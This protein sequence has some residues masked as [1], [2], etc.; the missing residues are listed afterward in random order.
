MGSY[1]FCFCVLIFIL[2]QYAHEAVGQVRGESPESMSLQMVERDAM[3]A[4]PEF[5][6]PAVPESVRTG[7]RLG[8]P[9]RTVEE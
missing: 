7:N 6:V 9:G 3:D 8:A 1:A 5:V 2:F 4:D